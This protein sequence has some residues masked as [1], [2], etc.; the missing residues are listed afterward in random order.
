MDSIIKAAKAIRKSDCGAWMKDCGSVFT[1]A[2]GRAKRIEL[3]KC[4]DRL[5]KTVENYEANNQL[6]P[7]QKRAGE[8]YVGVLMKKET[9][10]RQLVKWVKIH[11]WDSLEK[12]KDL[13]LRHLRTFTGDEPQQP[14]SAD[15]EIEAGVNFIMDTSFG[16]E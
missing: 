6:H 11:Y 8:H 10:D 13:I 12:D 2:E 14:D 3:M 16:G 4:L 5:Y 7:T 1:C 15:A 9:Y